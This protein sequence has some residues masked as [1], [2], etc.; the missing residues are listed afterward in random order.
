MF[1]L[2]KTKHEKGKKGTFSD[3][4]CLKITRKCF[5]IPLPRQFYCWYRLWDLKIAGIHMM[6]FYKSEIMQIHPR[7]IKIGLWVKSALCGLVAINWIGKGLVSPDGVVCVKFML[8]FHS[9]IPDMRRKKRSHT[10]LSHRK[11]WETSKKEK[12]PLRTMENFSVGMGN[13]SLLGGCSY[14]R[15]KLKLKSN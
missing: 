6:P 8:K 3:H 1:L 7:I 11:V 2:W 14:M 4:S 9:F 12:F 13:E 5:Q 15:R 10:K